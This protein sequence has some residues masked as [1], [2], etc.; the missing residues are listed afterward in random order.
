VHPHGVDQLA[1]GP[2]AVADG[3]ED[4]PP[5]RLG[6][7]LQDSDLRSHALNIPDAIYMRKYM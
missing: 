5:R 4:P 7:H 3:I 6:D 2:L 1:D